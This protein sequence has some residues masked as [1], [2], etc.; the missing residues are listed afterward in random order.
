MQINNFGY[1]KTPPPDTGQIWVLSSIVLRLVCRQ[2]Q[3]IGPQIF[4]I[5]VLFHIRSLVLSPIVF[6][7]LSWPH[8]C[9]PFG[10]RRISPKI[11][12]LKSL[13]KVFF[14]LMFAWIKKSIF[15]CVTF[16]KSKKKKGGRFWKKK[17]TF[18]GTFV[19]TAYKIY[20]KAWISAN[21]IE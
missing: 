5:C 20:V 3:T 17:K 7:N 19:G 15:F 10:T 2:V 9:S 6:F 12:V 14:Y 16:K 4:E 18:F 21:S 8:L 11:F 1:K 13:E